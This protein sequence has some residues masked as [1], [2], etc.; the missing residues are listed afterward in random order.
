ME[1]WKEDRTGISIS[2]ICIK[3]A[4]RRGEMWV[5]GRLL[6]TTYIPEARSKKRERKVQKNKQFTNPKKRKVLLIE[7]VFLLLLFLKNL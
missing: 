4:T 3:T 6:G 5:R 2:E 7:K 1:L